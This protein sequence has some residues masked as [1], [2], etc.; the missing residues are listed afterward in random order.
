MCD[1]VR[2][3]EIGVV[4]RPH[5]VRGEM[6][7]IFHNTNSNPLS[8]IDK[9]FLKTNNPSS[10]CKIDGIRPIAQGYLLTLAGVSSR[11][12]AQ[13]FT[14][15]KLYIKRSDLPAP[16]LDEFYVADLI[17]LEAWDGEELLGRISSSRE[18]G[19]IE[20]VTV[21]NDS[22]EIEVPLVE[23]YVNGIDFD[24]GRVLICNSDILPRAPIR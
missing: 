13:N 7:A 16:E 11:K 8:L 4:G 9:I 23:D 19:G 24:R 12:E 1:Q 15:A 3:I 22:E 5:G 6:K 14:G 10:N 20:V 17:N 2:I 18:Q 21:I